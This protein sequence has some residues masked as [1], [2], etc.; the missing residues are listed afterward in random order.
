MN[1]IIRL[2]HKLRYYIRNL[3]LR[4]PMNTYRILRKIT[5]CKNSKSYGKLY[6]ERLRIV[7]LRSITIRNLTEY[8]TTENYAS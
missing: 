6:Y 8:Y 1:L 2:H 4:N 5:N 3:K 7:E